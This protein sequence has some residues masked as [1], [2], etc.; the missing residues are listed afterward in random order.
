MNLIIHFCPVKKM[1]IKY[2]IYMKIQELKNVLLFVLLIALII[3][4]FYTSNALNKQLFSAL[5]VI[6]GALLINHISNHKHI[7]HE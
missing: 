6:I 1:N 4:Y 3:S 5:S 2:H 7:H